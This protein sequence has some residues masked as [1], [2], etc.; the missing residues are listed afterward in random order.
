V[1]SNLEVKPGGIT[2][3]RTWEF[4]VVPQTAGTLE[5]PSLAFWYFDPEARSIVKS[6]TRPLTLEVRGGVPGAVTPAPMSGPGIAQRGGPLPLRTDL[7]LPPRW[8][9]SIPGRWVG[10]AALGA[11]LLHGLLWGGDALGRIARASSP[12]AAP[13][14]VRSALGELKRV[15]REGMSKEAAAGLIEKTIHRV[16]GAMDGD[17]TERARSVRTLL[18]EVQAVRYAPQLGD[19][20]ERLRELATRAGDVVRKWA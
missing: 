10:F 11:L 2:G 14:G 12:V 17:E 18:E 16:F 9:A 6:A 3:S 13:A 4:V 1:K 5:V 8:A 15:G 19:Y 7:E 20:S